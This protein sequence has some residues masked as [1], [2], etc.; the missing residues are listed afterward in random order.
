MDLTA[1]ML[2]ACSDELLKLAAA[3][4]RMTVPQSR[5]G[6]RP[7]R[8]DTMLRKEKDGTLYKQAGAMTSTG[9][10]DGAPGVMPF[11]DPTSPSGRAR[12]KKK[13][14]EVASM[15]DAP[16][17]PDRLDGRDAAVT[18][19]GPGVSMGSTGLAYSNSGELS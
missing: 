5:I 10:S 2:H 9:S 19:T 13:R 15:D 11:E 12:L 3:R 7:M 1:R 4:A 17:K 8:V 14:G 18:Q 16:N 6:R